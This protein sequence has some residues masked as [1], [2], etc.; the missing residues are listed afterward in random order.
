MPRIVIT[1]TDF[2]IYWPSRLRALS[3]FLQQRDCELFIIEIAG[4][5]SPYAFAERDAA[6]GA[7]RWR[8]LFPESRMEDIPPAEAVE[9]LQLALDEVDPA[10]VLAGALAFPSGAGA[11]NWARRND[12]PIIIFDNARL[13]DVPR[14]ALVNHVKRRLHRNVDAVLIPAPSHEPSFRYW[15]VP[16]ER[17]FYG[18]NVVDTEWFAGRVEE[19]R[20]EA[21]KLRARMQLPSR[22]L[23]GIGR[24]IEQKNWDGLLHAWADFRA[25]TPSADLELVLVGD[26]PERPLLEKIAGERN[27]ERLHFRPFEAQEQLCRYYLLATALVLPS[28]GETWGLVVNEAMACGLPVLAS[29]D[30]GCAETLVSSDNGWSFDPGDR[31]EMTAAIEALNQLDDAGLATLGKRSREI[32]AEWSLDRFCRGAHDALEYA[33]ANPVPRRSPLDWLLMSLW[34]GRYR[35]T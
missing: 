4:K 31:A 2:R 24:Q 20:P 8:C 30:C 23:L 9:A 29:R 12:R 25:K 33:L 7:L 35:P 16:S 22:F 21:E 13:V 10:A 14:S 15:G 28:Y 17:V 11:L 3:T 27:I 18:L 26:G 5:G 32:V 34:K 1:H 19:L 6:P